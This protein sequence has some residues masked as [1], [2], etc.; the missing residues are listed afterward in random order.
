MTSVCRFA[1]LALLSAFFVLPARSQDSI[2][3]IG[4]HSGGVFAEFSMATVGQGQG[5]IRGGSGG[6]YFQGHVLGWSLRAL[7][8]PSGDSTHLYEATIGPRIAISLP[9]IKPFLEVGGGAGHAS[10]AT[11]N[12]MFGRSWGPAWQANLGVEHSLLPMVRWR[13]FDAGYGHIYAGPGVSPFTIG[14]GLALS[15]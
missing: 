1:A 10:Y 13:I 12:G 4:S 14:T 2:T 9:F 5:F 15:F 11:G 7:A 6:G 8:E 3:G